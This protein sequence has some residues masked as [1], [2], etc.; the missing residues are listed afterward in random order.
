M[1]EIDELD[2]EENIRQHTVPVVTLYDAE[3]E[4][5][6]AATFSN[7]DEVRSLYIFKLLT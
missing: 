3:E 6:K 4:F 5:M 7:A 1:E 2:E